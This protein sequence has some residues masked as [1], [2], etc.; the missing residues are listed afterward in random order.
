[1][2]L[3]FCTAWKTIGVR[4]A[5]LLLVDERGRMVR[6]HLASEQATAADD[7]ASSF[8]A[9]ARHVV[10]SAQRVDTSDLTHN[11]RTF[12]VPL[13]WQRCGIAKAGTTGVPLLADQR[14]SEFGSDPF[15]EFFGTPAYVAIPLR[16]RGKVAA[17][18]AADHGDS[19]D[20]IGVE[21]ISLVY[22]MAQQAA[23]AI[24]RLHETSD[25]ARKFRVLRKL[26]DIL[27]A[28]EDPQRFG[29]ALAA[30]LSML[31]R[32][33]G[34]N[35][36]LLK[37][38]VRNKTTHVKSVDNI[39]N[40]D[41][42]TDIAITN[43]FD[44]LLDRVAGS[45][46]AVRGDATHPML[47]DVA[48]Q[49]I[50]HFLALPL[51]A[52]GECLGA[53]VVYSEAR[54]ASSDDGEFGARDRLFLELCA[55]LLAER[56][57]SLYKA[58]QMSR[59][60]SMLEEVQSN[61][62]RERARARV[63]TR[64]QEQHEALVAGMRELRDVVGGR[65]PFEK[66]IARARETLDTL[67][68]ENTAFMDE[69]AA[70]KSALERVDLFALVQG[71]TEAWS[72]A[73]MAT[74]VE[75]TVR[76]PARGPVLLMDRESIVLALNNILGVLAPHV[77]KGDRVLIECSAAEGRAVI[78]VA[79]TAGKMDGTLLSRL[80]M[81]FAPSDG[82]GDPRA[83]LSAAGDILQRH[84][85]EITVRSSPSWRTILAM[86]F[87]VSANRDR[88]QERQDRRR[89]RERRLAE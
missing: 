75:L 49:A 84:S 58:E 60:E 1:M 65:Q 15:F 79:D 54:F 48:A 13:D 46:K 51:A 81:P 37:D 59:S 78:L 73:V 21:D 9:H 31:S 87:P 34:G 3:A 36:A 80:F 85:G 57:D 32:A 18:L 5:F 86:S 88:R 39:D 6:G 29:D 44:D 38:L 43:S 66:R 52:G 74:G 47:A 20:R 22:S 10:E 35:G 25:N 8:E 11:T 14:M 30:M 28:A 50:H 82:N 42:A 55:G 69:V 19:P 45:G 7:E 77:G 63:G 56:L 53:V 17:V 89:R 2:L 26:Q 61:L 4:R 24:E 27:A 16:V 12:T 72:P 64:A 40:D 41:R 67:E 33:M 76:I 68:R 62:V 83:A 23:T 71:V 70:M